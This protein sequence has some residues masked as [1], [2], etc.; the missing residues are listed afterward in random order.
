[1]RD[2]A[3]SIAVPTWPCGQNELSRRLRG[4][5]LGPYN[6]HE[7][8]HPAA[9]SVKAVLCNRGDAGTVT[10]PQQAD[11]PRPEPVGESNRTE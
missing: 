8:I 10:G 2:T 9:H 1:M 3:D 5:T 6:V 4:S 11:A 7:G